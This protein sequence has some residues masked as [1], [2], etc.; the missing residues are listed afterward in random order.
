MDNDCLAPYLKIFIDNE[1]LKAKKETIHSN[2]INKYVIDK[3][4]LF[5]LQEYNKSMNEGQSYYYCNIKPLIYTN[6][7]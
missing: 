4:N 5:E 7:K 3:L 2:N 6:Y 1:N